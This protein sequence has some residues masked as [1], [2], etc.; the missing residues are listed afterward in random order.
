MSLCLDGH[1]DQ[2]SVKIALQ[3]SFNL[4]SVSWT[5]NRSFSIYTKL[6]DALAEYVHPAHEETIS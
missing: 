3:P 2:S 6:M 5:I 4:Q 1:D